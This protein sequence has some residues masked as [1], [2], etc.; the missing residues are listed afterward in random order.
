MINYQNGICQSF[1]TNKTSVLLLQ[2][3]KSDKQGKGQQQNA[4][5]IPLTQSIETV[6]DYR[7]LL[8]QLKCLLH[9]IRELRQSKPNPD[10]IDIFQYKYSK[11][12][13]I[14]YVVNFCIL[15]IEIMYLK[16]MS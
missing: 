8:I 6:Y 7:H 4:M 2:Q 12:L 15:D 10:R 5:R 14:K 3:A 9:V 13:S 1:F 11:H 16:T